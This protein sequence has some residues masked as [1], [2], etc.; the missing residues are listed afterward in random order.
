MTIVE[1]ARVRR[2]G[3]SFTIT[4]HVDEESTPFDA[5]CYA[6]DDIDGWRRDHWSYVGVEV[7]TTMSSAAVWGVEYGHLCGRYIGL[8]QIVD[9]YARDLLAEAYAQEVTA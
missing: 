8:E 6:P 1:S 3:I 2:D 4:L 5:D 7:K 9:S